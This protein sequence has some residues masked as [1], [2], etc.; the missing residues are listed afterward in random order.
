ML[1]TKGLALKAIFFFIFLMVDADFTV[2]PRSVKDSYVNGTYDGE[3]HVIGAKNFESEASEI[4][5]VCICQPIHEDVSTL[6][7]SSSVSSE[8]SSNTEV[9]T[10][11]S[12]TH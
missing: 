11:S 8:I 12:S 7:S 9:E 1:F 6:S 2:T 4:K 5:Y 10:E 3:F